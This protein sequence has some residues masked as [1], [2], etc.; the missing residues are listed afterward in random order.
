MAKLRNPLF[1]NRAA[2][3]LAKGLVQFRT[4]AQGSHAYLPP[5][6]SRQNQYNPTAPQL[7][8]RRRFAL[9]LRTWRELTGNQKQ[10]WAT[11]AAQLAPDISGWNFFLRS[12]LSLPDG[13]LLTHT[14][15]PVLTHTQELIEKD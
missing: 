6:P 15:E 5:S 3:N 2:G 14:G 13:A 8:T 7:A 12:I 1:S 11:L 10:V 4:T 9:A